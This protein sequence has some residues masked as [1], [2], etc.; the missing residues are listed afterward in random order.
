[1]NENDGFKT[2]REIHTKAYNQMCFFIKHHILYG[3]YAF[4]VLL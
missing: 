2:E 1:M 4:I 3:I